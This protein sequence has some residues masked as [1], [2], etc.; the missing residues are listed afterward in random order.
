[1]AVL[2]RIKRKERKLFLEKETIL[3][4]LHN[5]FQNFEYIFLC[6]SVQYKIIVVKENYLFPCF[7]WTF[8][9]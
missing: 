2:N 8:I 6:I 5:F 4:K 1:M 7:A 9:R 3:F